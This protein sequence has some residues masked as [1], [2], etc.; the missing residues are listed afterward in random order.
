[1][2]A[3]RAARQIVGAIRERRAEIILTPAGQ[4][5]SRVAQLAPGLTSG[6]L[7]LVQRLALPGP[8]GAATAGGEGTPGQE[9]EPAFSRTAFDRLTALGR[10]AADR[11]NERQQRA[12]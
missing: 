5:V 10:T 12:R 7:H 3:E 1:M 4:V 9:L 8:S 11:F 6:V 2:D